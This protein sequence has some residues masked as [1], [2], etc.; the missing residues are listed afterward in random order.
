MRNG[1]WSCELLFCHD[2]MGY[3]Y[4]DMICSSFCSSIT[5]LQF[6]D[7]FKQ[8]AEWMELKFGGLPHDGTPQGWLTFGLTLLNPNHFLAFDWPRGFRA[9]ADRIVL[10]FDGKTHYGTP[11]AWLHFGHTP[12]NFCYF[13]ASDWLGDFHP[14]ADKPLIRLS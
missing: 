8:T 1:W 9:F 2:E 3:K 5:L 4:S 10:V 11:Q 7:I 6:L 14:L 12:L 13:Q